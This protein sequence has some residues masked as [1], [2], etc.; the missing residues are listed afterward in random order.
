MILLNSKKE[1]IKI[2]DIPFAKG[3]E[4][5][6]YRII[7]SPYFDCCV[8]YFHPGKIDSRIPKLDYMIKHQ[9][10]APTNSQYKICWPIDFVYSNG[11]RVGFIM[12]L[13]FARSHSLYDIYLKD[14]NPIFNRKTKVGVENRLKLL[15]NIATSINILH[16]EGY[17]LVD[18]KPQNILFTDS[19]QIS[20]I[21]LDSIQISRNNNLIFPATAFTID[22]AYPL[23]L[24]LIGKSEIISTRWDCYS[25]SIVAYQILLGIHP[26]TAS[27]EKKDM[28]GNEISGLA[29]LMFN[30]MFP[31][32]PRK[33]DILTMPT[34][35]YYF[36]CLPPKLQG[37]FIN[38]FNLNGTKPSMSMW[39]SVLIEVIN[40]K[41]FEENLFRENPRPPIFLVIEK[42]VIKEN[43]IDVLDIKWKSFYCDSIRINNI[44]VSSST[45][46]KIAIPQNREVIITT[47]NKKF[48]SRNQV[49]RFRQE[50]V[51]CIKC[52]SKFIDESDIFCTNC[53]SKRI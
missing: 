7:Q 45:G 18:F 49:L 19:G 41:T 25:F 6:I 34:I 16:K 50:S 30:N 13:S 51:F 11:N 20:M 44:D 40:N 15:F 1:R 47:Y 46:A 37:I 53:G 10:V 31:F 21:D 28:N 42:R 43:N 5:G 38:S 48:G 2:E 52:G 8:K 23:E 39:L 35:Q 14:D 3:G 26:F 33:A 24:N 22:Y 36:Y 17:V 4:G 9:L 12:P 29:E 27:T 32:G